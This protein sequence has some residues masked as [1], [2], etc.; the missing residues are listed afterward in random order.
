MGVRME[1]KPSLEELLYNTLG[2]KIYVSPSVPIVA[3]DILCAYIHTNYNSDRLIGIINFILPLYT[4]DTISHCWKKLAKRGD[5]FLHTYLTAIFY[6]SDDE[7]EAQKMHKEELRDLR[8]TADNL[9][10]KAIKLLKLVSAFRKPNNLDHYAFNPMVDAYYN[11]LREAE[12]LHVFI[13]LY[14][15]E[16]QTEDYNEVEMREVNTKNAKAIFFAK[17]LSMLCHSMGKPLNQE[18]AD[19]ISTLF[20]LDNYTADNV[21]KLLRKK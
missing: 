10:L 8:E 6:L 4:S 12:K 16:R 11:F 7:F 3:K 21:K 20:D 13:D 17:H 19:T 14:E 18:V 15:K 5:K 9:H 1:Q 2:K